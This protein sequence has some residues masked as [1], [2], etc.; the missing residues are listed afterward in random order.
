MSSISFFRYS[1]LTILLLAFL[2]ARAQPVTVTRSAVKVTEGGISY[3]MHTVEAGHTLFSIAK[4]YEV[5]QNEILRLNPGTSGGLK[6]GQVLKIPDT[7]SELSQ[8]AGANA[9]KTPSENQGYLIHKVEAGDN[10]FAIA[11]KYGVPVQDIS[12][13]NPQITSPENLT[14]GMEIRIPGAK[15]LGNA[16][17][18]M[19]EEKD[20]TIFHEVQK[21]ESLFGIAQQYKTHPD[22]IIAWNPVLNEKPLKKG[23]EI[24]IVIKVK[25]SKPV[26]IV[27]ETDAEIRYDTIVYQIQDKETVW[28]IAKKYNTTVDKIM[29]IN[30]ELKDG[31]KAGYYIYVPVPVTGSKKADNT[32]PWKPFGCENSRFKPKYKVALLIPLYLDEI[33]RISIPQVNDDLVRKPY[34]KSFTFIEFYQGLLIAVDSMKKAGLSIDLY[35][36]DTANDTIQVKK[37]L[38]KPE[39]AYMDMI[40]G[41]FFLPEHNLV[42]AFCARHDIKLVSPFARN[43]QILE[44]NSNIFQIN[45]ASDSKIAELARH[46]AKTYPDPNVIMVISNDEDDRGLSRTFKSNLE[47]YAINQT[48]KPQFTEVIYTEK[49]I[50]GVSTQL[51]ATRVNI[52]VNL[53]TGETSV[54]NY[55]S[56][57]AKLSKSFNIIM[58]G[59]PEWKDYRIFELNDLMAVKL[60]LFSNTFVD[61]KNPNAIAFL[62]E[63]RNRYKGDPE[64]NNYG[65]MGYDVGLYFL[66]ALY[67]Y[68]L[69]FENCLSQL[70]YTPVSS[71]FR[72]QQVKGKGYE[73]VYLNLFRYNDFN[74]EPVKQA[75]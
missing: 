9:A 69:D 3:Y 66:K 14:I 8:S 67:E 63:Y 34:F 4:V 10:L 64:E 6:V 40:I 47:A 75:K 22:S 58:F 65:Y 2:S 70:N 31:L 13:A 44:Q 21:G 45:A 15:Q 25:S 68:G 19:H 74:I 61:P 50:T 43:N 73:N 17:M 5:D 33:D 41:P 26:A 48:K 71:G 36:F 60:H 54:S 57:M 38:A 30:P 39:M 28:G 56:G 1:V 12:R 37:I 49:G 11:R 46:I 59:L 42:A 29:E 32:N 20:S 23:Q 53:I 52:I 16:L 51:D 7:G 35:V 55:V 24:K 27:Q 18:A 72:W 62:R